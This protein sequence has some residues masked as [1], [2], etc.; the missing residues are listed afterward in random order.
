MS[1]RS[2][3]LVEETGGPGVNHQPV[4]S[5]WQTVSHNVVHLA[6]IEIRTRNISGD[7][8]WLHRY[9]W[10]YQP[11]DHYHDSPLTFWNLSVKQIKLSSLNTNIGVNT[12]FAEY[13][14]LPEVRISIRA[15]C[16][17]L[18]D[19]VCQWLATGWWFTPGPPVSSTN[20][21]DLHDRMKYC[22]KWH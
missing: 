15:R 4:A 14:L 8:H 3:L 20:K 22:W 7:M 5:H 10:I 12:N 18:C 2:V 1:W 17:T 19:T 13:L 16:T 9:L 11:Y 6:L 21:T